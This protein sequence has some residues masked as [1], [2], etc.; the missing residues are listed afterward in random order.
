M[1]KGAFCSIGQLL[2]K[3]CCMRHLIL[4]VQ[5]LLDELPG[6]F[7][8]LVLNLFC[9]LDYWPHEPVKRFFSFSHTINHQLYVVH[10]KHATISKYLTGNSP[11]RKPAPTKIRCLI[12]Q[13]F[14]NNCP[15]EPNA[16]LVF[17]YAYYYSMPREW[18]KCTRSRNGS[19]PQKIV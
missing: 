15:I 18:R 1:H 13:N 7:H 8:K 11:R 10:I 16:P 5:V 3:C 19:P 2:G 17:Y 9:F 12:Q 4:Q 14:H 6:N